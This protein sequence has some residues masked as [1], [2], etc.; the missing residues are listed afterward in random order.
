MSSGYDDNSISTY[1]YIQFWTQAITAVYGRTT[2]QIDSFAAVVMLDERK[3]QKAVI[4][5]F[6][7]SATVISMPLL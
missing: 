7:D 6:S 1:M 5:M 4:V 3:L 2:L